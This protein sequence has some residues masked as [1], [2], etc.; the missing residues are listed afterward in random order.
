MG[1]SIG[2]P[3]VDGEEYTQVLK[4]DVMMKRA[5]GRS[6]KHVKNYRD[7][8]FVLTLKAL[9]YY[10]GTSLETRGDLKG[11]VI[12]RNIIKIEPVNEVVLK[13]QNCFVIE[14]LGLSLFIVAK[15]SKQRDSWVE[16][17]EDKLKEVRAQNG[18]SDSCPMPRT[19]CPQTEQSARIWVKK[20]YTFEE[21]HPQ[22]KNQTIF[23]HFNLSASISNQP[24]Y[25]KSIDTAPNDLIRLELDV[26][27]HI[28]SF[29]TVSDVA[30]VRCVCKRWLDLT[31]IGYVWSDVT[32]VK[33]SVPGV[34]SFCDSFGSY[35]KKLELRTVSGD[36]TSAIFNA[37]LLTHL[38]LEY[39]H[40]NLA[41]LP[42]FMLNLT[43][44]RISSCKIQDLGKMKIE[45][46]FEKLKYLVFHFRES[47]EQPQIE[48]ILSLCPSIEN[49]NISGN[50][51]LNSNVFKDNPFLQTLKLEYVKLD[52][53]HLTQHCPN[54]KKLSLVWSDFIGP[55]KGVFQQ[56][57]ILHIT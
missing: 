17:I 41:V 13:K 52:G 15:N 39:T 3:I 16:A 30:N 9:L 53:S 18:L 8:L 34:K 55:K 49:L 19:I 23:G 48:N 28:F 44:L 4:H 36:I 47:Y 31:D 6:N 20:Y 25:I 56:L 37:S 27:V 35:M 50:I 1:N 45:N 40:I 14:H 21:S 38:H 24:S 57:T 2:E 43:H 22:K 54:L 42:K 46:K 7:R 11:I 5:Q 12:L 29:L 32:G 10:D 26:V 33:M 51:A